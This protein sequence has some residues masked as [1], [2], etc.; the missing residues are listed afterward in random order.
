MGEVRLA[1]V[2]PERRAEQAARF[3]IA[4]TYASLDELCAS[5]VDAIALFTQRWLHGPQ[6][7]Q[8]LEAGKHVYSAVPAAI[9]LEEVA[10]LVR[11][12]SSTGLV[13][14]NGETSYYYP[15]VLYCR[16]RF[17]RGDFGRFVYGE[18][19]YTHDMSHGFYAGLPALAAATSG[20][21]PPPS[22]R[23]STPPTRR[24]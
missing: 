1:E 22:R 19:C 13:Y 11:P 6:A 10:D 17:A 18:A 5:D 15:S 24:A 23:C 16:D 12:S 2:L 4:R 9:T 14:M 20:R 3:G 7:V 8:A 21:R